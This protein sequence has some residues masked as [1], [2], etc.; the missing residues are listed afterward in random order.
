M[1]F[2]S[3]TADR[4]SETLANIKSDG[5]FTRRATPFGGTVG[6]RGIE[7]SAEIEPLAEAP[8]CPLSDAPLADLLCLV[9][10]TAEKPTIDSVVAV[11]FPL[12]LPMLLPVNNGECVADIALIESPG[13]LVTLCDV[14]NLVVLTVEHPYGRSSQRA[15]AVRYELHV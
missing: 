7:G 11:H 2:H 6:Q 4:E 10:L 15:R 12:C 3:N 9:S 8:V 13:D 14:H 5:A 1:E